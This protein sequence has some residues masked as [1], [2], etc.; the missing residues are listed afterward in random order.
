MS[1][2]YPEI[3]DRKRQQIFYS[4]RKVSTKYDLASNKV[5]TIGRRGEW[6]DYVD[7]F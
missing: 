2:I 5:H 6:K 7:L 3:L 1:K 4:F